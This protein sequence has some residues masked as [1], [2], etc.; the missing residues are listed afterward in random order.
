MQNIKERFE[1]KTSRNGAMSM[2]MIA[3]VICIVVVINLIVGQLPER[4]RNLDLTDNKLYEISDTSREIL[5]NLDKNVEIKVLAVKD[6]ADDRI[7]TF[8]S[9]Y[10]ALSDK[11]DVEWIDPVQHPSAL[12]KYDTSSNSI[13]V[14]CPDT[15]KSTTI[16]FNDILVV[17]EMSYYTTGS[18]E[19]VSFDGEGQMT[20]A[21]N[22]V[23]SD[24]SKNIYRTTGHGEGT[25]GSNV[26]DLMDKMN[27]KINELNLLMENKI[28]ED[29]DLLMMYAPTKDLTKDEAKLV[30][31][32]LQSG[33][34]VYLILGAVEDSLP[35]LEGVMKTYGLEMADGYI[36][37]PDRCYQGNYYY[38]FPEL[39]LS[40]KLAD[41]ISSQMVLLVNSRGMTTTDAARDGITVNPFMT[42]SDS[43]HAVTAD[44]DE[45]GSYI[46]GAVATEPVDVNDKDSD[47]Y[48]ASE[49]EDTG[50]S[51]AG[52]KEESDSSDSDVAENAEDS[53][54]SDG[55]AE[56][57]STA[58]ARLTVMTSP[59]M[60]D[61]QITS[62]FTTLEN[63]TLFMNTVSA[64][65]DDIQN[66]AI[67][68]K[69]L[70][71]SYN[72]MQHA[73]LISLALIFGI[74][75]IVLGGGFVVWWKRRK[76]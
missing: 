2:G 39:S 70:E 59:A 17:D 42:S 24:T 67:E 55:D 25:L 74:P 56:D 73:G 44:G 28:P 19:P 53:D 22:Y 43:A 23:I 58:E 64:N 48:D 49:A 34:K 38:I 1:S 54:T 29:C 45:E 57:S 20:S 6:S 3:I 9:K 15:D 68:P 35:N 60:I 69:S 11:L 65:F 32:Y 16:S 30:E 36:A 14:S 66:V 27:L 61:E 8:L 51:D 4:I 63:L 26:T 12:E 31:D 76:A 46:M 37:D 33:G 71:T 7:K 13:V 52:E 62:T 50:S 21:I 10:A 5:G 72:T 75:V 47:T 18:T 41:N 40:E